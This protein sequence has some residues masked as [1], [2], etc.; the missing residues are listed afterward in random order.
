MNDECV[1][2]MKPIV[3][4]DQTDPNLVGRSV[5]R[6]LSA[7]G[8]KAL[9][10]FADTVTLCC[11]RKVRSHIAHPDPGPGAERVRRHHRH[12]RF[13]GRCEVHHNNSFTMAPLRTLAQRTAP[14]VMAV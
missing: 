14:R 5:G 7:R 11:W 6:R 4:F 2:L 3:G 10:K 1:K 9:K 8:Q 12:R 13:V